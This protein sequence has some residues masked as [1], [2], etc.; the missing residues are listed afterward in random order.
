MFSL[1]VYVSELQIYKVF[2]GLSNLHKLLQNRKCG[3][4]TSCP[5]ITPSRDI[6]YVCT[7]STTINVSY[8]EGIPPIDTGLTHQHTCVDKR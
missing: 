1:L 5:I 2:G 7:C 3:M 4:Y 8:S 6:K